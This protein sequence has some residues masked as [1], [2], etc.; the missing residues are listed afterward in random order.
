MSPDVSAMG[1]RAPPKSPRAEL[2]RVEP[3]T[4]PLP[5]H[6][7]PDGRVI[8]DLMKV[9][10]PDLRVTMHPTAMSAQAPL[11]LSTACKEGMPLRCYV[12]KEM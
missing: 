3:A 1:T 10:P 8:P 5:R 2:Y 9:M 12:L 4:A 11:C 7:E 6:S